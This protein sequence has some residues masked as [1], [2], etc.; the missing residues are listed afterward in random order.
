MRGGPLRPIVFGLDLLT[1]ILSLGSL[2]RL[3]SAQLCRLPVPWQMP[4]IDDV[5]WRKAADEP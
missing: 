5:R 2:A 1:A 3:L 4:R